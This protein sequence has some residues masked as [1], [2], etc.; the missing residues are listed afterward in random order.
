MCSVSRF[1]LLTAQQCSLEQA[2]EPTAPAQMPRGTRSP[3]SRTQKASTLP[4]IT[5]HQS[6][7][8]P[9]FSEQAPD[10]LNYIF[11]SI[12]DLA[13]DSLKTGG[14]WILFALFP[15]ADMGTI[16]GQNAS[17]Y[18]CFGVSFRTRALT[19]PGEQRWGMMRRQATSPA[20]RLTR[21]ISSLC[22]RLW[23]QTGARPAARSVMS[24]GT[25]SW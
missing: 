10:S 14:F 5:H 25:P 17:I 7:N 3:G 1:F 4:E 12:F 8:L 24:P 16:A 15:G 11:V 19:F 2:F 22:T 23:R 9:L 20:G 18:P 13:L 21:A 6:L